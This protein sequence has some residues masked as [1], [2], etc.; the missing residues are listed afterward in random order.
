MTTSP[1]LK[2]KRTYTPT[3][4]VGKMLNRAKYLQSEIQRLENEL[5]PLRAEILT[6][7]QSR[8]LTSL[9]IPGFTAVLKTR[10][11]WTY[12]QSTQ[13]AALQLRVTQQYEQD[14]GKATND[15]TFY[16]ALTSKPTEPQS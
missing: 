1:T 12:T 10:S 14:K 2:R 16:I 9:E 15:P 13:D 6:H 7:L 5:K 4:A 8:G 11:H 3:G